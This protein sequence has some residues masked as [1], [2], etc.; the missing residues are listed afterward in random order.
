MASPRD[1]NDQVPETLSNLVMEC[2]K[3]NPLKRPADMKEVAR[4]LE[5]M[6]HAMNRQEGHSSS[7][8]A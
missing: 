7:T 6:R 5:I 2:V 1:L 4:R 8:V 3:T